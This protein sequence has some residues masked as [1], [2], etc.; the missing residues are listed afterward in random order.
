MELQALLKQWYCS[1]RKKSG[2][3]SLRVHQGRERL[4]PLMAPEEIDDVELM[5]NCLLCPRSFT[6]GAG[7]DLATR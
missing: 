6:A 7:C 4:L 3:E 5:K 1:N 2:R